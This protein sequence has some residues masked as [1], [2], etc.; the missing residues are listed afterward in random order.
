MRGPSRPR[1]AARRPGG[2][3]QRV[4]A[5]GH[6]HARHGREDGGHERGREE[7]GQQQPADQ[8]AQR[9]RDPRERGPRE[10][11]APRP[12]GLPHGHGH[13]HALVHVVH[14]HRDGQREAHRRILQGAGEGDEALRQIVQADR[15]GRHRAQAQHPPPVQAGRV[16]DVARHLRDGV[17]DGALEQHVGACAEG[18]GGHR[19]GGRRGAD[20]PAQPLDGGRQHLQEGDREHDA[21]GEAEGGPQPAAR[22]RASDDRQDAA[23]HRG[24]PGER[25]ESERGPERVHGGGPPDGRR[26]GC[27][28]PR[29]YRRRP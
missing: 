23:Q 4:E 28:H 1:P 22:G 6:H 14:G 27:D 3:Q 12:G 7:R 11:L 5:H 16:V 10:G 19:D 25:R 24:Q 17:G 2:G 13:G 20:R 29:D 9:L 15:Q 21:R 8:R 18:Q 26:A